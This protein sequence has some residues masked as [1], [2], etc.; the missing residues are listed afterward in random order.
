M[1]Q[2][3]AVLFC[4]NQ[5]PQGFHSMADSAAPRKSF[6]KDLFSGQNPRFFGGQYGV[7]IVQT[8]R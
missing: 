5:F 4:G 7:T 3:G 2:L 1:P 6:K 8:E